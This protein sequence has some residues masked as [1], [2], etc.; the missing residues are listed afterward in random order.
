MSPV[1]IGSASENMQFSAAITGFGLLMKQSE[2]QG[3]VSKQLILDLTENS[4]SFDPFG[5]REEFLD[6]ITNW[7][8]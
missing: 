5:Y 6:L 2:Y 4:L 7:Y 3:E 1:D 8:E